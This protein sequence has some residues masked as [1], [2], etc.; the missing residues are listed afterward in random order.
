MQYDLPKIGPWNATKDQKPEE[1]IQVLGL[2]IDNTD[3][4]NTKEHISLCFRELDDET[5]E[6]GWVDTRSDLGG[7][8]EPPQFWADVNWALE[9]YDDDKNDEEL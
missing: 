1:G 8:S 2:W 4:T 9:F 7:Y 5:G 6:Y 3:P